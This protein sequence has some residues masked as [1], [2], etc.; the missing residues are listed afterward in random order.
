MSSPIPEP[1]KP[2]RQADG[3]LS[4]LLHGYDSYYGYGSSFPT[5]VSRH[6][7]GWELP[8]EGARCEWALKRLRLIAE[9]REMAAKEI[10]SSYCTECGTV[11]CTERYNPDCVRDRWAKARYAALVRRDVNWS[12][13]PSRL[14]EKEE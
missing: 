12:R 11:G 9:V 5:E 14:L 6:L 13:V 4:C 1:C 3:R 8:P 7:V 10:E 2:F